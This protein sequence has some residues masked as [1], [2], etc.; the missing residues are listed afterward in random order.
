VAELDIE[1]YLQQILIQRKQITP[2]YDRSRIRDINTDL[3]PKDEFL[4][5]QTEE[6]P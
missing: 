4:L 1:N 3:Y 2:N 5:S 6:F